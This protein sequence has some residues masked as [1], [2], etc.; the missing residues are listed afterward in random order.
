MVVLVGC[1]LMDC[2][3]VGCSLMDCPLMGCSLM[4]CPLMDCPRG[5]H[6]TKALATKDQQENVSKLLIS[7]LAAGMTT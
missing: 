2:P 6:L 5:T 3:L 1:S 4:D 7:P